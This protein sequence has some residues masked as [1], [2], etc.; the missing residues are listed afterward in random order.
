MKHSSLTPFYILVLFSSLTLSAENC[1]ESAVN[2][3]GGSGTS[4]DFSDSSNYITT[5]ASQLPT[6]NVLRGSQACEVNSTRIDCNAS[7]TNFNFSSFFRT[8]TFTTPTVDQ[9]SANSATTNK[10]Y[11]SDQS[12]S[13]SEDYNDF[14]VRSGAQVSLLTT[15]NP[16]KIDYLKLADVDSFLSITN[17]NLFTLEV[18][19]GEMQHDT[20]LTLQNVQHFKTGD[21]TQG[22]N[23]NLVF[24]NVKTVDANTIS[25]N[26]SSCVNLKGTDTDYKFKNGI[27][28]TIANSTVIVDGALNLYSKSIKGYNL[29]LNANNI[30]VDTD[31][32]VDDGGQISIDS[33]DVQDVNVTVKGLTEFKANSQICLG[34]GDY[35]FHDLKIGGNVH[36][37]PLGDGTVRIFVDG[38][39]TDGSTASNNVAIN[40]GGDPSQMLFY[41]KN[42]FDIKSQA[43]QNA[44]LFIS[45]GNITFKSTDSH[46]NGALIANNNIKINAHNPN[47]VSYDGYVN[48][49]DTNSSA[50]TCTTSYPQGTYSISGRCDFALH[51]AHSCPVTPTSALP[52]SSYVSGL[53]DAWDTDRSITDRNIST[54]IA[55]KDFNITIAS[56]N[57]TND[58]T[59]TK[60]DIDIEYYLKDMIHNSSLSS[61]YAFDANNTAQINASFSNI[62][63]SAKDVN[64]IFKVCATYDGTTYVSYPYA[65]CSYDC[66]SNSEENTKIPCYR[67]F[68]NS[69][70]FAI[71]PNNFSITNIPSVIR[72]GSDLNITL[73]ALDYLRNPTQDYNET[74]QVQSTAPSIEFQ[75]INSSCFTGTLTLNPVNF[76]NGEANVTLKYSEVGDLNL[77]IEDTNTSEYALVD[78]DDTNDT[79]RIISPLSTTLHVYPDHFNINA[80]FKNFDNNT[81]TYISKD[82]NM[83]STLD[84]NITAENEQNSTTQNYNRLCYAQLTDTNISYTIENILNPR[85]LI[86]QEQNSS[87][88]NGTNIFIHDLNKSYFDIDNNGTAKLHE[89]VNFDRNVSDALNPFTMVITDINVTD[90]NNTRGDTILDQ[91]ATFIYGRTHAPRQRFSGSEGNVSL[92]YEAYC[93]GTDDYNITCNKALLPNNTASTYTDD[94]RWFKNTFHVPSTDGNISNIVQKNSSGIVTATSTTNTNP[95]VSTLTYDKSKGYPYKTTMQNSARSWLIYNKYDENATTNEFEIEFLNFGDWA[96]AHE[97]NTTTKTTAHTRTNRRSMW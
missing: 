45:D 47:A 91:N 95:D 69:D 1:I 31:F 94:P 76:M 93:N 43:P 28:G 15:Q 7:G 4:I 5:P 79:I 73:Q 85:T 78:V 86:Y 44:G 40:Q 71:R 36:L 41:V 65:N 13:S 27:G 63:S 81:F 70:N 51:K 19:T 23:V 64:V 37:D 48:H 74:L 17:D 34:A 29:Y 82:L 68:E 32:T 8:Q 50:L 33:N 92:Y 57:K 26:K 42:N 9:P 12:V 11:T 72:A 60:P 96:G 21:F 90:V 53:F 20:S 6:Q 97:T 46:I 67:H 59:E 84:I 80:N 77:T 22:Q 49:I 56:I 2:T 39:Y 62:Q 52:S 75:D 66:S 87:K 89:N 88:K 38:T 83:S 10:D 55:S 58:A 30:A 14:F 24:A 16:L 18:T 25:L 61:N 3:Y 35:Y 54:K